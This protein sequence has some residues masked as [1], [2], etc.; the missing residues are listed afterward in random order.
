MH[1]SYYYILRAFQ[2]TSGSISALVAG[3]DTI[4]GVAKDLSLWGSFL[5]NH[6]VERFASFTKD[7]ALAKNVRHLQPDLSEQALTLVFC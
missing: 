1:L 4:K 7:M 3:L 5:E 6:D 2:S